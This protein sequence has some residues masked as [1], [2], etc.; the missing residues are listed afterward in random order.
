MAPRRSRRGILSWS[1]GASP[2]LG[3]VMAG[4][5]G[6]DSGQVL[7][8]DNEHPVKQFPAQVPIRSLQIAF[9]QGACGRVWRAVMPS[10]VSI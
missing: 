7:L 10:A 5:L 4:V 2:N 8:V 3:R 9:A 6:E 1:S